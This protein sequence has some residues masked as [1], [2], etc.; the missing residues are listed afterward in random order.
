MSSDTRSTLDN[1]RQIVQ[2]SGYSYRVNDDQLRRIVESP[3]PQSVCE[4][5][6]RG[7]GGH[8]SGYQR[9]IGQIVAA[10]QAGSQSAPRDETPYTGEDE[11]ALMEIA[12]RLR[13]FAAGQGLPSAMVEEALVYSGLVQPEPEPEDDDVNVEGATQEAINTAILSTLKKMNKRLKGIEKSL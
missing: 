5:I 6:V 9:I 3:N 2:Q 11:G 4:D 8:P 12:D 7:L 10:V 13:T 1:V